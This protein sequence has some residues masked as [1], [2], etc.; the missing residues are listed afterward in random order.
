MSSKPH[1]AIGSVKRVAKSVESKEAFNIGDGAVLRLRECVMERIRELGEYA[2][3][4]TRRNK[5]KT[6]NKEML[7]EARGNSP[8]LCSVR[9]IN[10]SKGSLLPQSPIVKHLVEVNNNR[11]TDDAKEFVTQLM[12]C[13][14]IEIVKKAHKVAKAAKRKTIKERDVDAVCGDN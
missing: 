3:E 5:V 2:S 9:V 7:E 8:S 4:I 10:L 13:Y 6:I 11:T 14:L 1:I 12:S